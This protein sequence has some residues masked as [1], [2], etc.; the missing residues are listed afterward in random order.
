MVQDITTLFDPFQKR[1]NSLQETI[2]ICQKWTPVVQIKGVKPQ[3]HRI[4]GAQMT[5]YVQFDGFAFQVSARENSS[6][7]IAV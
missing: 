5:V 6:T 3:S 4:I 2:I 7:V 1:T